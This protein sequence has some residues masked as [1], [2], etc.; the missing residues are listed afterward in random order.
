M[1]LGSESRLVYE[2]LPEKIASQIPDKCL[3]CPRLLAVIEKGEALRDASRQAGLSSRNP[4]KRYITTRM[5]MNA[6][7]RLVNLSAQN[8]ISQMPD[9][10]GLVEY[11]EDGAEKPARCGVQEMEKLQ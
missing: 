6:D 11:L 2:A 10:T 7:Q 5:A 8:I 1:G 4:I 9:C 3:M